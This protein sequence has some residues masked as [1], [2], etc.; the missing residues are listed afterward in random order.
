MQ[1]VQMYLTDIQYKKVKE[2]SKETD[3]SM[4][5][6]LRR[7]LDAYIR[8]ECLRVKKI[9]LPDND[10]VNNVSEAEYRTNTR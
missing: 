4:A 9:A 10:E 1:R 5:E 8:R 3:M 6:I 2:L 7:A